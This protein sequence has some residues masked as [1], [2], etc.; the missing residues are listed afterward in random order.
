MRVAK[1][2]PARLAIG[3]ESSTRP[4]GLSIRSFSE[5]LLTPLIDGRDDLRACLCDRYPRCAS[6]WMAASPMLAMLLPTELGSPPPMYISLA[7]Y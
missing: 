1:V 2:L 6:S 5:F 4:S 7:F 3:V